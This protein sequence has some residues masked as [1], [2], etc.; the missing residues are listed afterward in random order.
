MTGAEKNVIDKTVRGDEKY[1]QNINRRIG[2]EI[3]EYLWIK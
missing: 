1:I 2:G 3:L